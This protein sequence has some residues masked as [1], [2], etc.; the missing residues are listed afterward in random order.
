MNKASLRIAFLWNGVTTHP[1][2]DGL[3]AALGI[4]STRHK[5]GYFEPSN[6]VDIK[7]FVPDRILYHAALTDPECDVVMDYPYKKALCFGGGSVED[8]NIRDF[9]LYFVESEINEREFGDRGKKWMRAFG[10]NDSIFYPM[11]LEKKYDGCY[12]GAFAKWKRP[13]LFAPLGNKAIAIGQFQDVEIE[14]YEICQQSGV[15]TKEYSSRYDVAV[16]INQSHA[17]VNPASFWGG[18]QRLTLEAMAC[19]V[20]PIVLDD[21][22]KNRE[23]VNEAGFGLIVNPD[24]NSIRDAIEDLKNNPMT[25]GR[26]YVMSRWSSKIYAQKLEEGLL[27]L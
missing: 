3:G 21:S 27:S 22:P 25:G 23:Y 12:A 20:P 17:V 18:G 24:F 4:L 2:D 14:C 15:D 10:V 26:E 9:D 5:V 13:E 6:W 11:K 7:E 8:R 19:N 16:A 1:H